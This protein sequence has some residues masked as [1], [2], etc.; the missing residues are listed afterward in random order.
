MQASGLTDFTPFIRT[1]AV[2]GQSYFLVHLASCIPP[3]PQQSPCGVAASAGSLF[4]EPSFTFGGQKSLM[5]V[6]FLV[7]WYGR[8]YF[9]FTELSL[10]STFWFS[11]LDNTSHLSFLMPARIPSDPCPCSHLHSYSSDISNHHYPHCHC[12]FHSFNKY[13]QSKYSAPSSV[14]GAVNITMN[15]PDKNPALKN[16]GDCRIDSFKLWC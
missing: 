11:Q 6:T 8:R 12:S 7:Y 3:A 13:L 16:P 15:K 5:A 1:S 9:H 14:L 4:W 10:F 2:W